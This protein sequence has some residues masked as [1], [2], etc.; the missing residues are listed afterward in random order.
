MDEPLS[1]WISVNERLPEDGV[2]VLVGYDFADNDPFIMTY[3]DGRWFYG[4]DGDFMLNNNIT[5]WMP[6]P[7]PPNE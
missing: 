5:H 2:D 1:N 6:L 7:E 4:I 3:E